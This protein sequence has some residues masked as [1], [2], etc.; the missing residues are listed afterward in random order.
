M[1]EDRDGRR[2]GYALVGTGAIAGVQAEALAAV[3]GARLV[4]VYNHTPEP[5][6]LPAD[7]H[8]LGG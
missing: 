7:R 2:I 8:V 6:Q 3:S 5:T 1:H 4:A